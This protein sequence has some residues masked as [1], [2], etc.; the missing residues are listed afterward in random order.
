MIQLNATTKLE[1]IRKKH[2]MVEAKMVATELVTKVI[3]RLDDGVVS[4]EKFLV[5]IAKLHHLIS[6]L[7][8]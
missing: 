5:F 7:R 4:F 2:S 3:D 8:P 1:E 6:S